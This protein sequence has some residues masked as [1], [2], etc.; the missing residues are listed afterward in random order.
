MQENGKIIITVVIILD[1]RNE[2]IIWQRSTK[3][4][5]SYNLSMFWFSVWVV[6]LMSLIYNKKTT[7]LCMT[8][9]VLLKFS[10]VPLQIA[11]LHL[12]TQLEVEF[13]LSEFTLI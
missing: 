11:E 6:S 10:S 13:P 7:F 2:A 12:M 9:F 4:D 3:V 1:R 5:V 8:L